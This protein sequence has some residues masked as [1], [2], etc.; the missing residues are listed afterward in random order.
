MP[1]VYILQF[2]NGNFYI[3]STN[4]LERRMRQHVNGHTH[5]TYRLG[6]FKLVLKQN[7][8]LLK[9]ARAVE[10]RLKKLK[11]HDYVAKIVQDGYIKMV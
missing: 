5:S 3:G 1:C 6:R 10:S 7:Y 8:S 2:E 11:R 9:D 4:D